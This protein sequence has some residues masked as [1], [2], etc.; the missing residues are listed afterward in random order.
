M[1]HPVGGEEGYKLIFEQIR[2]FRPEYLASGHLH[3]QSYVGKW[4]CSPVGPTICFNPGQPEI[5]AR[6]RPNC[7]YLDT[8]AHLAWWM[9]TRMTGKT[10]EHVVFD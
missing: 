10:V 5:P 8:S 9:N 4:Y 3:S 1:A 2:R 6:V 7:I